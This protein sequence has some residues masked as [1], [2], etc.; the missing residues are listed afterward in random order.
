MITLPN[1][2]APG[3]N[4]SYGQ[5]DYI[6]GKL[7]NENELLQTIY[8]SRILT[9]K[10]DNDNFTYVVLNTKVFSIKLVIGHTK[11][12]VFSSPAFMFEPFQDWTM[13]QK[14][15]IEVCYQADMMKHFPGKRRGINPGELFKTL[16]LGDC[17]EATYIDN[18]GFVTLEQTIQIVNECVRKS[19]A[20]MVMM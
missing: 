12:Q 13:V 7:D 10:N 16:E 4:T 5:K 11:S 15:S 3:S 14:L 6:T 9:T 19:R 18:K 8:R 17:F 1:T 2:L 20:Y